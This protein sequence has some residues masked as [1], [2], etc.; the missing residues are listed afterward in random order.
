MTDL[1]TG[2]NRGQPT[3]PETEQQ[4]AQAAGVAITPDGATALVGVEVFDEEFRSVGGRVSVWDTAPIRERAVLELPWPVWGVAV[5]PDGA[6]AVVNGAT[7]YA[8]VDVARGRLVGEP[9]TLPEMESVQLTAGAEVSPD[10]RWAALA[11]SQEIVIVDV[12]AGTIAHRARVVEAADRRVQAL[13]WTADSRSIAAG[14][15]AG[16]LHFVDRET[17]EPVAPRRLITGGWVV[18][19]ET[20]PD[21]T[22]MA[23]AGSDGDITLWDTATWTPYG[24]P[25]TDDRLWGW[26]TFAEDGRTLRAFFE[27]KE[28]VDIA[29]QPAAWVKAACAAANRN[30]TPDE[31]AVVLP[32]RPVSPTCPGVD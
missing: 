30:L 6:R 27:E 22:L 14:S 16:W 13:A 19:L 23:S 25:L 2:T 32:G 3:V 18:D 4:P 5:T 8:V 28:M 1:R 24:Q 12:A 7:G 11:R 15:D 29:V 20:S 17:L 21:G 31:S 9:V 10:G 26:L